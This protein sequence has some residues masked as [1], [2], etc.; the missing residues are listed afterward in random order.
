[1]VVTPRID[2]VG[3]ALPT[4]PDDGFC[5]RAFKAQPFPGDESIAGIEDLLAVRFRLE[6]GVKNHRWNANIRNTDKRGHENEW[7]SEQIAD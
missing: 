1:M 4:M 5:R 3:W 7:H 2:F 6:Q